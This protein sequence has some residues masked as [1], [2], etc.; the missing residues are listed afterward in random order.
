[1]SK[2]EI[3]K[4]ALSHFARS[5]YEGAS[6]SQI[7]DEV[8]IKKPSIYAHFKGKD[9]LFLHVIED[10][11]H[12]VQRGI[13]EYFKAHKDESPEKILR[14][15]FTWILEE[16]G[17]NDAAK[18]LLRMIYFPP[19]KLYQELADIAN[20]FIDGLQRTLIKYLKKMHQNGSFV[21]AN[22][23]AAA[24]AYL[25]LVDGAIVE[26]IYSSPDRYNKR[27][28]AAWLIYWRGVTSCPEG[29]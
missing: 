4:A 18:C 3:Q 15:L 27:V 22:Y 13:L 10:V 20:P 1:M 11:F 26:L 21:C 16:Y 29:V 23:E 9:D 7:A 25:T 28:E 6:L 14:G 12:T 5:G 2:L 24:I 8:G 19:D 17:L